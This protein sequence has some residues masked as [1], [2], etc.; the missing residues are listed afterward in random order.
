MWTEHSTLE[1]DRFML[2]RISEQQLSEVVRNDSA[3]GYVLR[4]RSD[5]FYGYSG[6]VVLCY[7]G[8]TRYFGF[9]RSCVEVE[10]KGVKCY[11]WC[12]EDIRRCIEYPCP[13]LGAGLEEWYFSPSEVL[14]EYP[15]VLK[16]DIGQERRL[17]K[18]RVRWGKLML[19]VVLGLFSLAFGAVVWLLAVVSP[20]L[21][22]LVC[23]VLL[24]VC[25]YR[26][27]CKVL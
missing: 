1:S 17:A 6:D 15:R 24:F 2:L 16:R 23:G 11:E 14:V 4:W 12:V 18:W 3:D 26:T 13:V 20:L 8:E 7:G 9:L 10:E 19:S 27:C 5:V 22:G 25:W 21:C